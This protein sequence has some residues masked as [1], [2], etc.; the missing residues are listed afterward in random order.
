MDLFDCVAPTRNGRNGQVYTDFGTHNIRNASNRT[1]SDPIDENCDCETC[2]TYSRGYLRHLLTA[3]ELLA[4]RLLSLHNV[5]FLIRL[6]EE[7]RR[8]IEAGSFE[9][10]SHDWLRRYLEGNK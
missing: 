1:S 6:T 2:T 10:W 9:S 8:Q 5:R 7:A 3:G 4:L